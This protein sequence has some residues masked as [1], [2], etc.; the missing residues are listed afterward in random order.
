M[1]VGR[2]FL[3]Q[4]LVGPFLDLA[5]FRSTFFRKFN[6]QYCRVKNLS[7]PVVGSAPDEGHPSKQKNSSS[8]LVEAQNERECAFFSGNK[9]PIQT[10]QIEA[11]TNNVPEALL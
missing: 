6:S 3:I 9:F 11:K 4:I 5:L 8:N 2:V 7:I 10:F 1:K